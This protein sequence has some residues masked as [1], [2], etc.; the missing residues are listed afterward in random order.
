[1][2]MFSPDGRMA[3][4]GARAVHTLLAESVEKVRASK[5]DLSRTYTNDFIDGR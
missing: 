4:D 1:M 2:T 5:I 3:A